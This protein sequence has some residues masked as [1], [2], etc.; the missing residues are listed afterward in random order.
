MVEVYWLQWGNE[1]HLGRHGVTPEEARQILSNRFITM[2]NLDEEQD[3]IYLVGETSGGR[4]LHSGAQSDRNGV[5]RAQE[6]S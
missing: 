4:I 5:D 2:P 1:E 6:E 3:R